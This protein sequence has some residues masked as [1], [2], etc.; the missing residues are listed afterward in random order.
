M[1]LTSTALRGHISL[2]NRRTLGNVGVVGEQVE[3]DAGASVAF[4]VGGSWGFREGALASPPA[5]WRVPD[6]AS[7]KRSISRGIARA[8]AFVDPCD[9]C[10]VRRQIRPSHDE[11]HGG[12]PIVP[13]WREREK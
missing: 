4:G 11:G 7:P 6:R 8:C 12:R 13:A 1:R 9:C 5:G 3:G 10:R 2:A